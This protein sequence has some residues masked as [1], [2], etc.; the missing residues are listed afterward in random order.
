MNTDREDRAIDGWCTVL[1][2][3]EKSPIVV[4]EHPDREKPGRGGCDAIVERKNAR[5]AVE[6]TSLDA[7]LR[8]REDDDRFRKV[9]LPITSAVESAFPDSWVE[10]EVPVHAIPTGEDWKQLRDRLLVRCLEAVDSMPLAS[11]YDLT[12]TRFDWPGEI[13]FPV[14]ISRQ[15]VSGDAPTCV[16]IRQAPADLPEQRADDVR[17][18]LDD[19]TARLQKY[20]DAGTTTVLLLDVD[21]VVL[22]NRDVVAKAFGKAAATW[23]RRDVVHE[24]YLVDS[25]RRVVWVYPLKIGDRLYPDLP[26]FREFFT[27]QCRTNYES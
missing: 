2:R 18:A 23:E 25:G 16:I 5:H 21:D 22:S 1:G 9:V 11:Y 15:A 17:R 12:R 27:E 10:M 13:P 24:V 8:R 6:H 7:Y 20:H 4:I 3:I 14:W 26:E 19:K